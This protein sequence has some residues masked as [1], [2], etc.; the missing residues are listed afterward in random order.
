MNTL[1]EMPERVF[2]MM[3]VSVAQLILRRRM[4]MVKVYCDICGK[5]LKG[6][7]EDTVNVRFNH[8]GTVD[9]KDEDAPKT[10]FE[11]CKDCAAEIRGYLMIPNKKNKQK[12]D[13]K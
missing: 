5:E 4:T 11:L 12:G 3:K 1:L 10:S 13:K 8:Y 6:N 7:F 9:F 2:S